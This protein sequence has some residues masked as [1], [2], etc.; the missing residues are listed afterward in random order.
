MTSSVKATKSF[1]SQL[2]SSACPVVLLKRYLAMSKMPPDS[3]DF[4]FKPISKGKGSY[5]LVAPDKPISYS[6]TRGTFRR[7]LQSLGVEPSKFGLHSLRSGG[8]T[9]EANNGVKPKVQAKDTYVDNNLEQRLEVTRFLGLWGRF[10]VLFSGIIS[11]NL[12]RLAQF[13]VSLCMP[14]VGSQQASLNK[15]VWFT[16][17]CY[18]LCSGD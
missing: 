17:L 5:K 15:L 9:V 13:F 11:P 4:I 14:R 16:L 10:R 8:A 12:V 6:T 1:I 18:L 3:K 7:D 2:S